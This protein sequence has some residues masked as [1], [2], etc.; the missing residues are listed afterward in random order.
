MS[1]FRFK[2]WRNDYTVTM[3]IFEQPEGTRDKHLIFEHNFVARIAQTAE[4]RQ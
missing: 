3:K 4:H 2:V 1:K